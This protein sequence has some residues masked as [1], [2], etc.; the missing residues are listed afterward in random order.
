MGQKVHPIGFRIGVIKDWQSKWYAQKE[1]TSLVQ[2][3]R[4]VRDLIFSKF[5][6]AGISKVEIDRSS[7]QVTA[8][9]HASRPGIVI[10]RSGQ[11][12]D[13]LRTQ[14]EAKT[15]KRVRVNIQEIRVPELD[16]FLVAKNIAEQLERRVAYR[17]AIKQAVTRTMQRGARGVKVLA[18]GR[19]GGAEMSRNEKEMEGRVPLQTIRADIDYGIAV[20]HTALGAIGVKVWIYKGDILPERK[21]KAPEVPEIAQVEETPPAVEIEITNIEADG[22]V[23]SEVDKGEDS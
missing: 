15:G 11:R 9:I 6:E 10:G 13:E 17:R 8:T 18:S 1:Y 16:A 14:L 19:L 5:K 20:A 12:V 22:A 23:N 7:N 21:R 4:T 2:E 3:D